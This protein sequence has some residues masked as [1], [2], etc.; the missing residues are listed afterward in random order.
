MKG[1]GQLGSQ[2]LESAAP[3]QPSPPPERRVEEKAFE[4]EM[5]W[6]GLCVGAECARQQLG[7]P[8]VR[9]NTHAHS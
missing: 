1:T 6:T 8:P 2:A 3:P 4:A 5:A 9:G 7:P